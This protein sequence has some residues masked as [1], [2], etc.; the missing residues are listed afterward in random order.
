MSQV[1][2]PTPTIAPASWEWGIAPHYIGLFLWIGFFDRLAL[3]VLRDGGLLP[4]VAGAT[5]GAALAFV[6]LY[7][8][9]A[10]LGLRTRATLRELTGRAF[11]EAGAKGLDVLIGLAQVVVFC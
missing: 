9:P 11:G 6:L 7:L 10:A 8:G 4:S 2:K 5:A 3:P 1:T